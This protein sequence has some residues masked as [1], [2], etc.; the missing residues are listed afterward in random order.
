MLLLLESFVEQDRFKMQYIDLRGSFL[1]SLSFQRLVGM[2]RQSDQNGSI[3]ELAK[4]LPLTT[5]YAYLKVTLFGLAVAEHVRMAVSPSLYPFLSWVMLTNGGY[6]T[7]RRTCR[8]EKE[9]W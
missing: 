1:G 9:Y 3:S 5:I 4:Q 8:R 2:I 7:S 6:V